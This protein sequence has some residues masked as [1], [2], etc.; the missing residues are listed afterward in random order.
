ML[1]CG[2]LI[3]GAR[4]EARMRIGGAGKAGA[5]DGIKKMKRKVFGGK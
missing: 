5:M 1:D 2:A 3:K 4:F